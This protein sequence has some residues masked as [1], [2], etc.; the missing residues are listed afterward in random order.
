ML[1]LSNRGRF[2]DRLYNFPVSHR[3]N[4]HNYCPYVFPGGFHALSSLHLWIWIF[5]YWI[6]LESS[7]LSSHLFLGLVSK[8]ISFS[9][10][11]HWNTGL[12]LLCIFKNIA[13][14]ISATTMRT[15]ESENISWFCWP[16]GYTREIT[17]CAMSIS[18]LTW[19]VLILNIFLVYFI[20]GLPHTVIS[21]LS[22][23]YL[24]A[25]F[26]WSSCLPSQITGG[27]FILILNF[28]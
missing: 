16:L 7:L 15:Q 9:F 18:S 24:S 11:L 12:R 23:V 19:N 4:K 21:H 26:F 14:D 27:Q 1:D 20:L 8:K 6:P 3:P 22:S 17:C 10:A 13:L 2:S 28:W 25:I 5:A